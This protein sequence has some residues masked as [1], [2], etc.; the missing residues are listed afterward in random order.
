MKR[1]LVVA[2]CLAA[3]AGAAAGRGIRLVPSVAH[4]EFSNCDGGQA[5]TVPD[6][7][8]LMRV[9]DETA[10]LCLDDAGCS[11]GGEFFTANAMQSLDFRASDGGTLLSCRSTGMTADVVLTLQGP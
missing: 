11:A 5:Q 9:K 8:Y 1:A 6:G 7:T 2:F 4:I 3:F 10:W